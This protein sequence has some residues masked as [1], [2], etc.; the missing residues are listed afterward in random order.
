MQLGLQD[1]V[2]FPGEPFGL[3][4]NET[5]LPQMLKKLDYSTHMVGKVSDRGMSY[6]VKLTIKGLPLDYMVFITDLNT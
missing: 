2:I 6:C 4:L 1:G 3:G 5:L